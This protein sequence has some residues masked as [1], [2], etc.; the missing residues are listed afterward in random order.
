[1]EFLKQLTHDNVKW[2]K[3]FDTF[4]SVAYDD[5]DDA[6]F[7]DDSVEDDCAQVQSIETNTTLSQTIE[8][9]PIVSN[10]SSEN[11]HVSIRTDPYAFEDTENITPSVP[12][13]RIVK[14]KKKTKSVEI[15]H[16]PIV[17]LSPILSNATRTIRTKQKRKCPMMDCDDSMP[18][19]Q[20]K[21]K[22]N[23]QH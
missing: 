5:D 20:P 2:T 22:K 21:N 13:R 16:R 18:T 1:M 10:E 9:E 7:E 15:P 8:S 14:K 17:L 23:K 3:N 4:D 12:R 6:E 19:H 11:S